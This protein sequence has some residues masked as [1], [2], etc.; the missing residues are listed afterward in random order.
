[1]FNEFYLVLLVVLVVTRFTTRYHS[2]SFVVIPCYS[3]HLSFSLVVTQRITCLLYCKRLKNVELRRKKSNTNY[4][5]SSYP[6]AIQK[7]KSTRFQ[8]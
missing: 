1:M 2:S 7:F 5:E 4:I 8:K 3:L 6:F